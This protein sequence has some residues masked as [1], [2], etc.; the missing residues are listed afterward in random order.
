MNILILK[1]EDFDFYIEWPNDPADQEELCRDIIK[2]RLFYDFYNK[3]DGA[4]AAI[5]NNKCKRFLFDR[6]HYEYEDLEVVKVSK[7]Y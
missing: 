3:E 2:K 5:T 1:E 7:S 4:E 6:E